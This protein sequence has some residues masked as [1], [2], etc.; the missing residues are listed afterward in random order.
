MNILSRIKRLSSADR[1]DY[2][3]QVVNLRRIAQH[4]YLPMIISDVEKLDYLNH[5]IKVKSEVNFIGKLE[6]YLNNEVNKFENLIGG[7]SAG[8]MKTPT[9]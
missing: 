9:K 1:F 4:Y 6:E 2:H 7:C 3:G 5:I 8:W